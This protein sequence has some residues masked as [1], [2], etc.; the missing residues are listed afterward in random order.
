[1]KFLILSCNTG[2]GHHSSASALSDYFTQQGHQCDILD[3][4]DFLHPAK[5]RLISEG[6][7]L[8]YR[9]A[10]RLFGLGY[11]FEEKHP[12]KFIISQCES[13]GESFYREAT[14]TDYDAV[15]CV[16]VF[17]GLIVTAAIRQFGFCVPSFFIATDYTCSPGA[18]DSELDGY[19]IPHEGL[20]AEFM[21]CGVPEDKLMATGIPVRPAFYTKLPREQARRELGLPTE[22]KL[23]LLTCGSMGAGP[24]E[25]LAQLLDRALSAQDHLVVVCGTNERLKKR[26]ENARLSPAVRIV[27]FTQQMDLYMD[28]ADLML[29]K[30]GGLTTTEVLMKRLPVVYINAVPGCETRNLDFMVGRGYG[31]TAKTA[32]GLTALTCSLLQDDSRLEAWQKTLARDFPNCAVETIYSHVVSQINPS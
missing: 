15:L 13:C 10:P 20:K 14:K 18:G 7:V 6:H 22:G 4:L 17:A 29:T 2:G 26:L 11:R 27:G 12:N 8:L 23:V 24:M 1:M 19:F 9:R 28:A 16:H 25:K 21:S 32:R 5:A 3:C 30:P 31:T